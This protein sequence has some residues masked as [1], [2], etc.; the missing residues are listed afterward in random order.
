MTM[1]GTRVFTQYM[2][3]EPGSLF[4]KEYRRRDPGPGNML[5]VSLLEMRYNMAQ[6]E[7]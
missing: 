4:L 7:I 1:P 2:G 3:D 5:L 6:G